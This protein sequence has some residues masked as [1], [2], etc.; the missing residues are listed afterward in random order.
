[1]T[2]RDPAESEFRLHG[3]PQDGQAALR[4]P[5][6]ATIVFPHVN[7]DPA[8]PDF[9]RHQYD[10]RSGDYLGIVPERP[11]VPYVPLPMTWPRRRRLVVRHLRAA[12]NAFR[13]R[14]EDDE[15][16]DW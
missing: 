9:V 12:W 13:G 7:P 11:V 2:T 5:G 8:G 14:Y 6:V 4:I 1:M 16:Y 10:A 3:G 15:E